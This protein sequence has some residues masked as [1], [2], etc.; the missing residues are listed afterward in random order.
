MNSS[1]A[2]ALSLLMLQVNSKINESV[3]FVKDKGT[4][5]E[6]DSYRAQA[7]Q[8]MAALLDV[9]NSIYER[10]PHLQPEELGGP[11][12]IQKPILGDRFYVPKEDENV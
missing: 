11:Y 10:Y 9:C 1:D 3:W 12:S 6:F 4:A 7:A 5:E 2:E 8:V